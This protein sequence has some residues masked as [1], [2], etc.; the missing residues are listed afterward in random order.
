MSPKYDS[1]L[2][3]LHEC[4]Y[5]FVVDLNL[6]PQAVDNGNGEEEDLDGAPLSDADGEDLDGVPLDGA[7]LMKSL[8]RL[9]SDDD[10]DG[11]P[12]TYNFGFSTFPILVH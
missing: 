1:N 9:P 10:I 2:V 11:V 5:N 4:D 6:C 3:K 7:A 12:C 8:K